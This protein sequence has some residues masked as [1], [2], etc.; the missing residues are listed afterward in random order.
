MLRF[1]TA[2]LLVLA[3]AALPTSYAAPPPAAPAKGDATLR[4][5]SFNIRYG[6]AKD[7]PDHWDR[8]RDLLVDTIRK[9]DPDLLGTQE[10]LLEQAEFLAEK[11]PQY[12]WLGVGRD[13][14]KRK[15]ESVAIYWKKDRFEKQDGGHFWLSETP[16]VP[17]SKS[18]DTSL[19][20]MA[21]WVK[22]RDRKA[23]GRA[24][25]LVWVN[26]HFDHMGK[27]ARL[28]SGKVIR[29]WL[30]KNAADLPVVV[31]GDFNTDAGSAPFKALV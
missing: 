15:G 23:D 14:G 25:Q 18:W 3:A 11:F 4:V 5:M 7:G 26:T 9:F 16:D 27:Q 28:E 22:L 17:A 21:T 1:L 10:T 20:R 12:A 29:A 30:R 24:S 19:T 13:D 6:T 31:T 2:G 8:R